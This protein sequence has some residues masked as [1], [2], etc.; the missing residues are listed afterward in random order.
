MCQEEIH[1][2]TRSKAEVYSQ[3]NL[4]PRLGCIGSKSEAL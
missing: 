1:A 4:Y 3:P 2:P